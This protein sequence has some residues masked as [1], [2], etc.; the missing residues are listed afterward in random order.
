MHD[1]VFNVVYSHTLILL[2]IVP[3]QVCSGMGTEMG[4]EFPCPAQESQ[5]PKRV[6][7]A[8]KTKL[9]GV[10]SVRSLEPRLIS[11]HSSACASMTRR[12]S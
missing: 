2:S 8:G 5:P 6:D 10:A 1:V 12:C 3:L 9:A 4:V 11:L 7:T